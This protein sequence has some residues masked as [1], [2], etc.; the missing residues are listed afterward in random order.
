MK[1]LTAEQVV[2]VLDILTTLIQQRRIVF[3]VTL[4]RAM[5]RGHG[6]QPYSLDL[7]SAF[8]DAR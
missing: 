7:A 6:P 8:H 1:D 5:H 2:I 3:T 4:N